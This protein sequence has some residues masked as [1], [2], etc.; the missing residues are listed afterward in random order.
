M[1]CRD[2]V[3]RVWVGGVESEG[4]IRTTGLRDQWVSAPFLTTPAFEYASMSE[5]YGNPKLRSEE[6]GEYIDMFEN[7]LS[8][9]PIIQ[10][11]LTRR[12]LGASQ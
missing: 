9:I 10:E 4:E 3:G 6:Y 1:F 7:Y 8:K 11:Y 2:K 12:G 5:G